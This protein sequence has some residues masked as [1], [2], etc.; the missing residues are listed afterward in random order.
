[1]LVQVYS[2][3]EGKEQIKV[4]KTRTFIV[5]KGSMR[6]PRNVI[7]RSLRLRR[8]SLQTKRL[9]AGM[10]LVTISCTFSIASISLALLSDQAWTQYSSGEQIDADKTGMKISGTVSQTFFEMIQAN[11]SP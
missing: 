3:V 5:L 8:R 2:Y 10:F 4:E 1:M 11:T 9:E 6:T 7:C